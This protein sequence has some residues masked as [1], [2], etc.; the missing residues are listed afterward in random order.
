MNYDIIKELISEQQ[1][2]ALM[3]LE[4]KKVQKTAKEAIELYQLLL[5]V[6]DSVNK[7]I[8]KSLT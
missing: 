8:L 6:Y 5:D 3:L 4:E 7:V 2:L 1:L